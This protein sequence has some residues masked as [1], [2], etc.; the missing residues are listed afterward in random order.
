VVLGHTYELQREIDVLVDDVH[1]H[2]GDFN[3]FSRPQL[4]LADLD[5]CMRAGA[6]LGHSAPRERCTAAE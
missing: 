6:K 5:D 3:M 2:V 4:A 1:L